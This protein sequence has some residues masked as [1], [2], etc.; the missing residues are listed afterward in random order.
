MRTTSAIA[1]EIATFTHRFAHVQLLWSAAKQLILNLLMS[2]WNLMDPDLM[3]HHLSHWGLFT[4][5]A[6]MRA[7]TAIALMIATIIHRFALAQLL[8]SAALQLKGG[9]MDLDLM[10]YLL[11]DL[12]LD[13]MYLGHLL[14]ST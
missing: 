10:K 11:M 5:L 8:R 13:R 12:S 3:N 14:L 1:L 9:L 2:Q 6:R 7:S 4:A